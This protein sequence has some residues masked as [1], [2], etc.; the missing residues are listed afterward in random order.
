MFKNPFSFKGRITRTEYGISLLLNIIVVLS[1]ILYY[2]ETNYIIF[3]LIPVDIWFFNAQYV[4]RCHDF[5]KSGW[6]QF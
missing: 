1:I 4:K 3:I 5:G 6:Y 2:K